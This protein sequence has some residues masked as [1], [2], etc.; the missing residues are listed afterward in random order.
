MKYIHHHLGLGDHIICNGIVRHLRQVH[1]QVS[2]FT[3]HHNFKN[4]EHMYRDD[5]NIIVISAGEDADADDYIRKN[6]IIDSDVIKVGFKRLWEIGAPS[7]DIGFYS[8]AGLPF[9]DRFNKFQ[10]VRD[11]EKE[12]FVYNQLNPNNEP[13]IFIHDDASRGFRIDRSRI[14][15]SLKV[16]END[17]RFGI[18]DFLKVIENA[19]EVHVMQSSMKDLINSYKF[20][21]PTFHFH[22][23]V[24]GYDGFL[25]SVGLNSYNKIY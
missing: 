21:K 22:N 16:I 13:Y 18:F 23:Y 6:N 4:V 3:K 20:D 9:E 19:Q 8:L 2:V 14:N 25:D 15:S 5:D 17:M 10:Y 1:G 24:R 12:D 7:F 11:A